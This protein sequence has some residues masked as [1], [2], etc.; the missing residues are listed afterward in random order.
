LK[1][2]N[3]EG[4]K[5]R[6]RDKGREGDKEREEPSIILSLSLLSPC[7]SGTVGTF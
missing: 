1:P 4:D 6:E 5:E 3:K 7:L 2:S